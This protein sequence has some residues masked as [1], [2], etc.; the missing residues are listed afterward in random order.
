MKVEVIKS[1][2]QLFPFVLVA[3]HGN[4][5]IRTNLIAKRIAEKLDISAVIN[6][7][8]KRGDDVDVANNIADCNN[9]EHCDNKEVKKTFL[10]PL[11]ECIDVKLWRPTSIIYL[12]GMQDIPNYDMVFG[13]GDGNPSRTT[14]NNNHITERLLQCLSFTNLKVAKAKAG[15]PYAGWDVRNLNQ[16]RNIDL[17]QVWNK[18][19][20]IKT[21]AL[22]QSHLYSMQIEIAYKLRK[23]DFDARNIADDL[24]HV[25]KLWN[26]MT[27]FTH[28]VTWNEV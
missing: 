19:W 4:T 5:D 22:Q 18:H 1:K 15:N 6:N 27:S 28:N 20:G 9:L 16:L 14:M 3:P 10:K 2:K 25:L 13:F 26:S 12:H 21:L 17:S 8:W 24:I 23:T 7:K 11:L